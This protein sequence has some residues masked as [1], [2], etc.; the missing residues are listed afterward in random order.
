M[1][2]ATSSGSTK[3]RLFGLALE[4]RDP[5]FQLRRLDGHGQS[6][7]EARF[8]PIFQSGDFLGIAVAGQDDLLAAF[9]QAV[10]GVEKFFLGALLARQKLHVVDQQG[11]QATR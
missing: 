8:Q 11:V 3:L 6:G 7:A 2:K 9:Q 1:K 5:G 4:N 10:E